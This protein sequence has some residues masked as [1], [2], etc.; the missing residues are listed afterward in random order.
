MI[1]LS[2]DCQCET[3]LT[4]YCNV[5]T[6]QTKGGGRGKWSHDGQDSVL[7]GKKKLELAVRFFEEN[8]TRTT[9]P[10]SFIVGHCLIFEFELDIDSE[11]KVLMETWSMFNID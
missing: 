10:E 2:F 6:K 7:L 1:T 11:S 8:G 3:V 5:P 4:G 9:L